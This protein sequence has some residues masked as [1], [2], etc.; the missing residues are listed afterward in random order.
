MSP[1]GL[2]TIEWPY[3]AVV[4][5]DSMWIEAAFELL[6]SNAL[7]PVD[8]DEAD[9]RLMLVIF[10]FFYALFVLSAARAVL[11]APGDI[12]SWLRSDGKSDL[13]FSD[14]PV[15]SQQNLRVYP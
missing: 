7:L 9:L 15:H 6:N 5:T 2:D 12:P 8:L 3:S 10:Q 1:N 14:K 4:S 13:R 11:T